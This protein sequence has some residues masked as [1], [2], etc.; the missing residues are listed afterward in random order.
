MQT[1]NRESQSLSLR[2]S[3]SS[4]TLVHSD[5]NNRVGK[6]QLLLLNA[7]CQSNYFIVD[8]RRLVIR[9]VNLHEFK[10]LDAP[11][12]TMRRFKIKLKTGTR[13]EFSRLIPTMK[14][15]E[16]EG[17]LGI[18][19][20]TYGGCKAILNLT[21]TVLNG[22]TDVNFQA[23]LLDATSLLL[24]HG[25]GTY[26]N[27]TPAYFLGFIARVYSIFV[28]TQAVWQQSF[29]SE[30]LDSLLILGASIGLP[31]SVFGILRR[32]SLLTNKK[33]GDHPGLFLELVQAVS[34]YFMDIVEKITWLPM[35]IKDFFRKLFGFGAMQKLIYDM[36]FA[37]N[38]WQQDKRLMLKA[39]FRERIKRIKT[40]ID[41]NP[42]TPER[43][44]T[45]IN[46]KQDYATLERMNTGAKSFEKCSRQEPVCIILEGPP[47]VMKTVVMLHIVKLLNR[48]YYTHIVKST[49]DGKD[50]YDGYSNEDIFIMD[51]VG[52]QGI[53]QWRT[54]I[55]MVSSVKMPLEC[56]A[57]DLK[58]TKY[59]DSKYILITTNNFSNIHGLTKSDG[60]SDLDAL[61]RR[62][63]VFNFSS[64]QAVSY[65]RFDIYKNSW[66]SEFLHPTRIKNK[67]VGSTMDIAI[68]IT[69]VA[70]Q[71]EEY[72]RNI[73]GEIEL[74]E[75][76][77]AIGREAIDEMKSQY[78]DCESFAAVSCVLNAINSSMAASLSDILYSI[79]DFLQNNIKNHPV[80]LLGMAAYGLYSLFNTCLNE[81]VALDS[82]ASVLSSWQVALKS[83]NKTVSIVNGVPL[84][85]EGTSNTLVESVNKQVKIVKIINKTGE[86]EITH[87]LVSGT[88][89]L[90]PAHTIY[91]TRGTLILYNTQED[92]VLEN[93]ALD[94]CK[95][96]VILEDRIN[97][98]AIL[99]VPLLNNTP[100][101]NLSH[102]F[103]YVDRPANNL[104]FV[105]SGDPVRINGNVQPLEQVPVYTTK[106]GEVR[107]QQVLTYEMTSKGFCGS[108][109]VDS[110]SGVIGFHVAGDQEKVGIAKV[111]SQSLKARIQHILNDGFGNDS[112]ILPVEQGNFSGM[113]TKSEKISDG[114]KKTHL[115][116]SKVHGLF[117]ETKK[118][119]NL[120]ALG[121]F[122]VKERAKR[123]HKIVRTID[124]EEL[125]F[126]GD[127]LD[128]ILPNFVSITDKEVIKG[129]D[130]LSS[131][132]KDSV[133]GMDFPLPKE[134]YFDFEKGELKPNFS[135][136]LNEYRYQAL[137]KYPDKITQHHT[138]KDELRLLH[139]V[140]KPR[141]FGVDSLA[142]QF[143]MKRLLGDLF[144]KIRN[145][146]WD[147]GIAIGLNP[148]EDWDKLY[149]CLHKCKLVWDGDIGE[150]DDSISPEIQN[151][152]NFK[153]SKK[154]V[155]TLEDRII[156]ERILELAVQS[157]VIAGNKSMFKTH[158]MLSGMW[159]TNLF[160][161]LINRCY[162]AGWF[163]RNYKK[164]YNKK[165]TISQFLNLVVDFVQGDDKIVGMKIYDKNFTAKTM[166]EYY[167][168]YGMTFTDAKKGV[169]D[170]EGKSLFDCA[171]LKRTF[172]F[173]DDLRKIMGPIDLETLTNSIMWFKDDNDEEEILQD[174]ILVF[175]REI[176][177][178]HPSIRKQMLKKLEDFLIEN[179]VEYSFKDEDYLRKAYLDDPQGLYE[180]TKYTNGKN[181]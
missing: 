143:E 89:I 14:Y 84:I 38:E 21:S 103:K 56:A 171:F 15:F 93:R 78:Y 164:V 146:K 165:P 133:S 168:S 156:L 86:T 178:H 29:T 77:V 180:H 141:T 114:P 11:V 48:S 35:G 102:L 160:N 32:M 136:V 66:T 118:P 10:Q 65:K 73:S 174:K 127:F 57:V 134:E 81:E 142:T 90:L 135:T 12:I 167:E 68:W 23:L 177:L 147:N 176:Y 122:T 74:T 149:K 152:V 97:D 46:F 140:N 124:Y 37:I 148:Y 20:G 130:G 2:G 151:M 36:R 83:K 106:F 99:K 50:H 34:T 43:L 158:G 150:W 27:W 131:I 128:F 22:K 13:S 154:F 157:W 33:V 69:A 59:F 51:D 87:A 49:L 181:Y 162:T 52:Q 173:H 80:L 45:M 159:I 108:L 79:L 163:Y 123:M 7:N 64:K 111:F 60:I 107:P 62:A 153:V 161:S 88:N 24:Q 155:G 41:A 144:V 19:T 67:K 175:Q 25:A 44:R 132:N 85:S 47:G 61:F 42:D 54:V 76:Q 28:R 16:S 145:T 63:H 9:R 110:Q 121:E 58:D 53:S 117:P 113:V 166:K 101:R 92:F 112:E 39:D 4:E 8:V 109:I 96:Q 5:N 82:N 94:N 55:N 100:Y 138:L 30:S 139:K 179:K 129:K 91:E 70:E 120:R 75:S 125:E 170:Y 115:K 6:P 26:N 31:E 137:T 17:L 71:L 18:I 104:Y 40:E 116:P 72:Y 95:F 169:I 119:A 126:M 105:W 3:T 98:V 1:Q 172:L